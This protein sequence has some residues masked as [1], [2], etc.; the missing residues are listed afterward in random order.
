MDFDDLEVED[1]LKPKKKKKKRINSKKKGNRGELLVGK[2]L[3]KRFD[4]EFSRTLG[5]GNRWSQTAYLPKHASDTFSGDLVCPANFRWVVEAKDG[6]DDDIELHNIIA[7]GK[8]H[9]ELEEWIKDIKE[10]AKRSGREPL[11]CWKK[12]YIPWLAFIKI[13]ETNKIPAAKK[14]KFSMQYTDN[15][16]ETWI[17]VSLD[18][19]LELDDK[20]FFEEN[21]GNN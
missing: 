2:V 7:K 17:I 21:D 1:I 11:I 13:T 8:G 4:F 10:D 3:K 12:K 18:S 9:S 19:V 15:D 20:F 16:G 5:S 6:Y 14:F